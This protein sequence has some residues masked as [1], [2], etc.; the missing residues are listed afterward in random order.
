M[1]SSDNN[2]SAETTKTISEE[3]TFIE[4]PLENMFL[5]HIPTISI[6]LIFYIFSIIY[7]NISN[8]VCV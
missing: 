4:L 6:F 3:D 1:K 7:N 2:W 8:D 5:S